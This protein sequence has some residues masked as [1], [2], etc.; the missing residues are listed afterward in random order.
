M[1]VGRNSIK[2]VCPPVP[3][4][5]PASHTVQGGKLLGHFTITNKTRISMTNYV[6]NV[7]NINKCRHL[8]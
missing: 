5:A 4:P 1:K 6:K 7:E 3:Q 8:G 2:E